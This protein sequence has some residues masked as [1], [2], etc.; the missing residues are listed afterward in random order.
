MGYILKMPFHRA[1]KLINKANIERE[2][3]KLF[4]LYTSAYPHMTKE[5]YMSFDE[6]A[7]KAMPSEK[8]YDTRS[9]EEIMDEIEEIKK[10]FNNQN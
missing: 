3:D 10:K 6:F 4:A 9:K 7:E 2:K 8:H 5:N 1:I